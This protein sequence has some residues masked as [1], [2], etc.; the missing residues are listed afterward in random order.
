[1]FTIPCF[2]ERFSEIFL[3]FQSIL[4]MSPCTP[5]TLLVAWVSATLTLHGQIY[6][7]CAIAWLIRFILLG[8]RHGSSKLS[9]VFT[10]PISNWF[11]SFSSPDGTM[12]SDSKCTADQT[13]C[14]WGHFSPLF[15]FLVLPDWPGCTAT[16]FLMQPWHY[17]TW[18]APM[19]NSNPVTVTMQQTPWTGTNM[20]RVE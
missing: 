5:C 2:Q 18:C 6:Q 1:M 3:L 13:C 7:L 17:T 10:D 11:R 19:L 4:Y 20:W 9:D 14:I 12:R 8:S 16:A 15:D